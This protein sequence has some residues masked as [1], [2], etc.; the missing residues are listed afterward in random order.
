VFPAPD[1]KDAKSDV[2]YL[3]G[4]ICMVLLGALP[5]IALMGQ[6][7]LEDSPTPYPAIF[8]AVP[9]I[10]SF[11]AIL[12]SFAAT[13]FL[14]GLVSTTRMR[15]TVALLLIPCVLVASG[16]VEGVRTNNVVL[17]IAAVGAIC[18]FPALIGVLLLIIGVEVLRMSAN[19]AD[20]LLY[21]VV[22]AASAP[23]K[24]PFKYLAA[25]LGAF[26]GLVRAVL[27]FFNLM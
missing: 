7:M 24:S 27:G 1:P 19:K 15:L 3:Y 20:R 22:N 9:F 5:L 6:Q 10:A 2:I 16:P 4:W 11:L 25:A 21:A 8:M 13:F 14:I 17:A 12:M 18:F 23:A 26:V